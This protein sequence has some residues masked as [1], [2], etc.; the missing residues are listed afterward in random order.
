MENAVSTVMGLEIPCDEEDSRSVGRG[1]G[2]CCSE[3]N[4][5]RPQKTRS[6]YGLLPEVDLKELL[7]RKHRFFCMKLKAH[8]RIVTRRPHLPILHNH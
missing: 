3:R 2:S 6:D 4:A 7:S 8:H 1:Q 5:R